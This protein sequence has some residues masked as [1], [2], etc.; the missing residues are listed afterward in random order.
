MHCVEH[1]EVL[2]VAEHVGQS[3]NL[4]V[5]FLRDIGTNCPT[6]RLAGRWV[7]IV[8]WSGVVFVWPDEIAM[9]ATSSS[10]KP[11]P[12]IKVIVTRRAIAISM[13][14]SENLYDSGFWYVCRWLFTLTG[15]PRENFGYIL[16]ADT[17][18]RWW[19]YAVG[20]F[21]TTKSNSNSLTCSMTVLNTVIE[22][23]ELQIYA[24]HYLIHHVIYH[25]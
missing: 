9:R 8:S 22:D 16:M 11:L 25:E 12:V 24:F 23:L 3:S 1:V 5:E 4:Q 19:N 7:I 14:C 20:K 2:V 15:D 17:S 13:D 21:P 10:A 18:L 6:D